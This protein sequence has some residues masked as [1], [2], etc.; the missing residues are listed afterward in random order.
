[1]VLDPAGRFDIIILE[2][3]SGWSEVGRRLRILSKQLGNG[4]SEEEEWISGDRT[5]TTINIIITIINIMARSIS[6]IIDTVGS[7]DGGSER[8]RGCVGTKS[9]I[10]RFMWAIERLGGPDQATPED[11]LR[12][13]NTPNVTREAVA[14]HLRKV[15]EEFRKKL[16]IINPIIDIREAHH[17]HH[18]VHDLLHS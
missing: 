6:T 18:H 17:H 10:T 13:M 11:I 16:Q 3:D 9:T 12:L 1:M 2:G 14:S 15:G 4:K 8:R 7:D 5:R